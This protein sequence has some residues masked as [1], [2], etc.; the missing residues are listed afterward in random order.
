MANNG[1]GY[2]TLYASTGATNVTVNSLVV[3]M[4]GNN[5]GAGAVTPITG[6]V[7]NGGTSFNSDRFIFAAKDGT[8][9]GWRGALGTSAELAATTNGA[10]YKGLAIGT[11]AVG[12]HLY[13]T[14]FAHGTVNAFNGSFN[15]VS[16]TGS[17]TDPNLPA[18]YAPFGIR[19]IGNQLYVTYAV[20]NPATGDDVA[21]PGNGVV[22]LYDLDGNFVRRLTTGGVL[23]SPWGLAMAPAGFGPFGGNL[24][25]G[26]FGDGA[27]NAFDPATG[28]LVG[29]L[30][31]KSNTPIAIDGLWGLDFGNGSSGG[32]TDVLYFTAGP[33]DEGHGLLGSIAV[34]EP[35]TLVLLLGGTSL[36]R[37]RRA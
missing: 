28:N 20:R 6:A 32:P 12:D 27:I 26:N 29:T 22:D 25:V 33:G 30:M 21:G 3:S 31:D 24:L 37:R 35:G 1:T 19:N 14:D 17:F 23:N 16:L 8:I 10:S 7:F 18:G 36:L 2:S 4:P 34:P 11:N 9:N 5:P 15:A 13:G